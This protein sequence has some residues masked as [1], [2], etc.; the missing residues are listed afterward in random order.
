MADDLIRN[1][2]RDCWEWGLDTDEGKRVRL[3]DVYYNWED[4]IL[5]LDFGMQSYYV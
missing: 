2:K 4:S 5:F 1:I 3:E